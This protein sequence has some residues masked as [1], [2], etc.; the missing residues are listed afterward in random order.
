[1]LNFYTIRD[2][3]KDYKN[4]KLK[5]LA[6]FLYKKLGITS[7]ISSFFGLACGIGSAFFLFSG[8]YIFTILI[9]AFMFADIFD[10]AIAQLEK[11]KKL[12]WLIDGAVDRA[13]TSGLILALIFNSGNFNF[14]A[15]LAIYLLTHIL[16]VY[17]RF[18]LKKE[19][20]IIHPDGIFL[21][22]LIFYFYDFG[23]YFLLC[24]TV[25]NFFLILRNSRFNQPVQHKESG[26]SPHKHEEFTWAN[27]IS[28]MRPLLIILA[29]VQLK[30]Q[31]VLL[32]LSIAA[33]ILM[34]VLDGMVARRSAR[35]SRLGAHIDIAADRAVELIVLFTYAGWG[36]ISWIFPL[37]FTI[38]GL[39]TDFLRLLNGI[40][41]DAEYKTPLSLGKADN[42]F[43]R[44]FYG[45]IKLA[46]FSILPV[47]PKTGLILMVI[48]LATNLYRGLPVI[49]SARAKVLIVIFCKK[50]FR[51]SPGK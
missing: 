32:G 48:A 22:A 7:N 25:L 37:I 38:R 35:L 4:H 16:Y 51:S 14:L 8:H 19:P 33:I 49:F 27:F 12:G 43:M 28:I 6:G 20:S 31:P 36:L 9:T 47:F 30:Y 44:G 10:G 2:R 45:A 39:E 21:F 18:F 24:A 17:K 11:D 23:I 50:V 34:D 1:M 3:V 42:R 5:P 26:R 46:A 13:I 41:K 15:V 40:Y 29:L